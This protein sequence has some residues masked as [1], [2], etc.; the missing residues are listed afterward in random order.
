ME[1]CLSNVTSR[2]STW[3]IDSV[4]AD[5]A[6]LPLFTLSSKQVN[7]KKGLSQNLDHY[8]EAAKGRD[9]GW[10]CR[11]EE[12]VLG[13]DSTDS[14]G[15]TF[16]KT[17]W[18]H[19]FNLH[20]SKGMRQ[21]SFLSVQNPQAYFAA[22][23]KEQQIAREKVKL[24]NSENTIAPQLQS[25]WMFLCYCSWVWSWHR[26]ANFQPSWKISGTVSNASFHL[27]QRHQ[28]MV[29]ENNFCKGS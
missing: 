28:F 26:A 19:D 24:S 8:G 3:Q 23:E 20:L 5:A 2:H 6:A 25:L 14:L 13:S 22:F 1:Y 12:V 7:G 9:W 15:L 4:K 11:R 18:S 10:G 16:L 17:S 29:N 27:E 21:S